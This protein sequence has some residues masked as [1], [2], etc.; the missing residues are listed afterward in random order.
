MITRISVDAIIG[1]GRR[2]AFVLRN[3]IF[4]IR[5]KA[6]GAVTLDG[7]LDPL[8]PEDPLADAAVV[9]RRSVDQT[10]PVNRRKVL[11]HIDLEAKIVEAFQAI[12]TERRQPRKTFFRASSQTLRR[13]RFV[14]RDAKLAAIAF[15]KQ[16]VNRLGTTR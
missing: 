3:E 11:P 10:A 4:R 1:F 13:I 6:F 16:F 15:R 14:R 5:L 7:V 9:D 8:E 12:Q 2:F